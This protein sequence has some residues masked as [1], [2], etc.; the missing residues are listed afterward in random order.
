VLPVDMFCLLVSCVQMD[1]LTPAGAVWIC[2]T[3]LS[4]LR[5]LC[6]ALWRCITN[7]HWFI[8]PVSQAQMGSDTDPKSNKACSL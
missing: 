3:Q 4:I 6:W 7:L 1:S 8:S 2:I 5:E